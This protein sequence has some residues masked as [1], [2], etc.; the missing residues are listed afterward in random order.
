MK[1]HLIAIIF[2]LSG[3]KTFGQV[4]DTLVGTVSYRTAQSTYVK[5]GNTSQIASGDT[6]FIIRDNQYLPALIVRHTSSM[7][8][9]GEPIAEIQLNLS[10]QV[11][12]RIKPKAPD[13]TPVKETPPREIPS[14]VEVPAVPVPEA[15]HEES[16]ESGALVMKES[17][18]GRLST[19]FYSN[20]FNAAPD[21]IQRMRYTFSMQANHLGD[22]RF[23]SETYISFRHQLDDWKAEKVE[24]SRALRV[25][26]LSVRYEAGKH[27]LLALGR[28]VNTHISNIGA[29]DGLQAE[30][31]LGKM[32][33]GGFAGTRPDHQDYGIN[34]DLLQF[35]AFAAHQ[36]ESK[37]G[38]MRNSIAIVE[39]RNQSMTDRR[40]AYFQHSSNLIKNI[41][42]FSSFEVDLYER[43]DS[44]AKSAFN[45][46]GAYFSLQYRPSRKW[47]FFGSYDA[48][49]N[50][51]YYETYRN[52]IDELIEQETRQGLRFRVNYRP[53]KY[54]SIGSSAGY[55]FQKDHG[56]RSMNMQHYIT[57]S[58]V[59]GIKASVTASATILEND[60]LHGLIYG[61][62]IS[63]DVIKQK[64]YGELE[65]RRVDYSYGNSE[66]SLKQNIAGVN[67]SWRVRKK[68]SLSVDYEGIFETDR[69]NHRVHVNVVQRF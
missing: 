23:S 43:P 25:Y 61:V 55:R 10:D 36:T 40:F 8:V 32:V 68:L 49:K 63:R 9:V 54:V 58:R 45:I 24:M 13:K 1:R 38:Q 26:N 69:S 17:I 35:G 20:V 5:F 48:R 66:L 53:V 14:E 19:S 64:V 37:H 57:H 4:A 42:L 59:P 22:S 28:R 30:H 29:I 2:L 44:V 12:Y 62:R 65:Y 50:V 39:Q 33:I 31:A 3:L 6:L 41:S 67:L 11:I 51:I 47:T 15:E 52:F 7:S 60:Y 16:G 21:N 34:F 27:T 46:T 18:R 56:A